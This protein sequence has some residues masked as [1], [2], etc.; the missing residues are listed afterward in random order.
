MERGGLKSAIL[1]EIR[2]CRRRTAVQLSESIPGVDLSYVYRILRDL[3]RGG[4]I[5]RKFSARSPA[6]IYEFVRWD[7]TLPYPP[8]KAED[9]FALL[10]AWSD[11]K[12][13]PQI[14][15]SLPGLPLI[16]EGL[17][18]HTLSVAE[19]EPPD[20][21]L[22]DVLRA[23][24][25]TLRVHLDQLALVVNGL[26]NSGV[27]TSAGKSAAYLMTEEYATIKELHER[28]VETNGRHPAE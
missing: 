19:G 5:T 18:R 28:I 2:R 4:F 15:S 26:A 3:E 23:S 12:W 6:H 9:M 1:S 10:R 8:L 14:L 27:W 24:L 11:R 20:Q 16:L 25:D 13:E 22:L 17:Y 7:A 21:H